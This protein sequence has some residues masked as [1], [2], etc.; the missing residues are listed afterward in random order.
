MSK[1]GPKELQV[2][3]SGIPAGTLCEHDTGAISFSY[4]EDYE[5]LPLSLNMPVSNAIYNDKLVRPY[6]FG[7]LPDNLETRRAIGREHGISG[8]NPFALLS[9]IGFDCPGAVQFCAE[10]QLGD[11][12][13]REVTYKKIS[14]EDI[15]ARLKSLSDS[16]DESWQ[17]TQEHWSLGGQQSKIAL[18]QFG[19]DWYECD[20]AAATT[21]ILK[22]GI[23]GLFHQALNEHFCLELAASCGIPAAKSA[24][25]S[26]DGI[27]AIVIER[28]DR[29]IVEPFEVL[30]FHQEDFCQALGVAPDHKYTT[31]DGP[32]ARDIMMLL[33]KCANPLATQIDFAAEL[34]FNYLI[35]APDA[36]AKNYSI[37]LGL[38]KDI[39]LTPLY[40]VASGLPYALKT[41]SGRSKEWTAAMGIGGENR[42][43]RVSKANIERFAES[44]VSDPELMINLVANLAN[45]ILDEMPGIAQRIAIQTGADELIERLVPPIEDL[46]KKTLQQL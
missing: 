19:E 43:G 21:H 30:R 5:G 18:A 13:N 27:N 31:D 34:F 23:K 1:F 14:I 26:F 9:V 38:N 36:H 42:F 37:F 3:I 8:N 12:L 33:A 28:F 24:Y 40:D 11:L 22:P 44:F 25:M 39:R 10:E 35:G 17:T 20:G 32:S 15:G 4:H 16:S 29:E 41:A 2:V 46:C 45:K 7:L 6:L